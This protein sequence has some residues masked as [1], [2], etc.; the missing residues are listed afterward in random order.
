MASDQ[1]GKKPSLAARVPA[2]LYSIVMGLAGLGGAWLQAAQL[3]AWPAAPGFGLIVLAGIAWLVVTALLAV[4][5]V[6]ARER[7][8]AEL[9]HPSHG[10]P[11]TL[12][13]ATLCLLVPLFDAWTPALAR[14]ILLVGA[15][16]A[17]ALGAGLVGRWVSE[18]RELSSFTPTLHFPLVAGGL[19]GALGAGV[20]GMPGLGVM[21]FGAGLFAWLIG[22]SVSLH[23]LLFGEPLPPPMRPLVAIELAPP[24]IGAVAW[25]VLSEGAPD[26]LAA[27]FFGYALFLAAL[28][29]GLARWFAAAP[30]GPPWWAF[31]FPAAA[32]SNAAIRFALGYPETGL[33]VLAV[34]LFALANAIALYVALRTA[35][36]LARGR[37]L[38][39]G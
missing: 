32:L 20:L 1:P 7:F 8:D 17:V 37:F 4:K 25:I 21:L 29:A 15:F 10:A 5:F 11:Y 12:A 2:G 23:R 16:G 14:P 24:A 36:A 33:T 26:A 34:G 9:A 30:F 18:R 13:P 39:P 19:L 35:V 22:A 28:L 38:P 6:T 27:L 31:T 3:L